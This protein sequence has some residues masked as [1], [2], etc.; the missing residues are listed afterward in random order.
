MRYLNEAHEILAN[1]YIDLVNDA[2]KKSKN[3]PRGSIIKCC[4]CG[5]C[6]VTLKKIHSKFYACTDCINKKT[7]EKAIEKRKKNAGGVK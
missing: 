4:E 1:A 3:K 5:R 7:V 2:L 6:D